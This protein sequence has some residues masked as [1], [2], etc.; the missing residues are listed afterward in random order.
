MAHE[1]SNEA[2]FFTRLFL[3][4]LLTYLLR[5][6]VMKSVAILGHGSRIIHISLVCCYVY[7]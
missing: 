1:V 5:L 6:L 3:G 7:E 2:S 4:C